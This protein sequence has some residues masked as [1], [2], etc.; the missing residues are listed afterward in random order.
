VRLPIRR[1]PALVTAGLLTLGLAG[2]GAVHA[3]GTV[4]PQSTGCAP[5]PAGDHVIDLGGGHPPVRLHV[6]HGAAPATGRP[7]VLVLPGYSQDGAA[8]EAYTGYDRL[9]NQRN[10]LVAYPTATGSPPSWNISGNQPG[11]PDD[12]AYL[13][14]VIKALTGPVACADPSRVGVTGVSNGG[15]M[16]VRLACDAADLIAAAAPVA[17]GYSSLP[18]CE[19]QRPLPILEVHGL[20]DEVVPYGGK[21]PNRAGAVDRFLAE[22]RDRDGCRQRAVRSAP[23]PNVQEMRWF[24][25]G[26]RQVLHDRVLDA[27][28]GWPGEA[29]LRPFSTTLRTWRFLSA[30]RAPGVSR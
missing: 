30:F 17:G 18:A 20:R 19:P 10:F 9:A 28:H 16:T 13:R 27:E 12:V 5:P 21:G 4:S 23:A 7:L 6:P 14:Y 3:G 26:G 25:A 22:W 15:G 2:A 24:C 1:A 29:S 11:K 8:I